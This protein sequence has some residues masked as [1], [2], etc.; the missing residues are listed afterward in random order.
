M[1]LFLYNVDD[2]D[3]KRDYSTGTMTFKIEVKINNLTSK[4]KQLSFRFVSANQKF[5]NAAFQ[6]E[7][8]R[9]EGLA[10]KLKLVKQQLTRAEVRDFKIDNL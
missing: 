5:V 2:N 9:L 6:K 10:S 3:L 8:Q 1:N 7:K 4:T